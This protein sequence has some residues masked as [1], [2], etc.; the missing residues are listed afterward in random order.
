MTLTKRK[1]Q[2]KLERKIC[3]PQELCLLCNKSIKN[4]SHHFFC[5]S[6]YRPGLMYSEEM[7]KKLKEIRDKE[8]KKNEIC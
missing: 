6:C 1:K 2:V 8:M 3:N 5:S 7:K 4:G